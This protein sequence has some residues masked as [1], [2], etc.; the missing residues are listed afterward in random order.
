VVSREP[1]SPDLVVANPFTD[2][3][4]ATLSGAVGGLEAERWPSSA[5]IS[6]D[7]SIFVAPNGKGLTLWDTKTWRQAAIVVGASPE[8]VGKEALE[9]ECFSADRRLAA[10]SRT[11][12]VN[13]ARGSKQTCTIGVW[14]LRKGTLLRDIQPEGALSDWAKVA[15]PS[16]NTAFHVDKRARYVLFDAPAKSLV[17]HEVLVG[18]N[19]AKNTITYIWGFEAWDI[20]T[21]KLCLSRTVAHSPQLIAV[22]P[23]GR[24]IIVA[25]EK[26]N[27]V[28]QQQQ[29]NLTAWDVFCQRETSKPRPSA[30]INQ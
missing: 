18:W 22:S 29:W 9:V 17:C 30:T 20:T 10:I 26:E 21:G 2:D 6:P 19:T 16:S 14:D 25:E 7:G 27:G 8:A 24:T 13:T 11:V 12:T 5:R 23:D 4:V 1:F 15:S 3:D 28:G